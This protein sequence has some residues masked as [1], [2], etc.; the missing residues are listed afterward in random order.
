MD[1]GPKPPSVKGPPD[2]FTG[3]VFIDAIAQAHGDSPA[4]IAFVHF[5]LEPARRG[6]ATP[7]ARRSTSPRAKA[8]SRAGTNRS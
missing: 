3:E 5:T 7:W 2:R 8:A 1:I 6:T 4:T